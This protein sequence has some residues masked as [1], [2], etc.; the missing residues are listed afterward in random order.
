ML[1]RARASFPSPVAF[2]QSQSCAGKVSARTKPRGVRR[3]VKATGSLKILGTTCTATL[4]LKLPKK[5]KG[6]RVKV[7]LA[8]AGNS[9]VVKFSKT[10]THKVR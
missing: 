4:S 1:F 9:A 5:F 3:T 7:K 6:K 8:F 10:F 2:A